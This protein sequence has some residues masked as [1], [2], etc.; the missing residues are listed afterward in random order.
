MAKCKFLY[1]FF[2]ALFYIS[3]HEKPG[4]I[5]KTAPP[6][7]N[8]I[9]S[10]KKKAKEIKKVVPNSK[11]AT[12]FFTQYGKDNPETGAII[13]TDLGDIHLK[14]F[15]DTPLHRAS[16]V[17]LVKEGYFDLT[18]FH[19]V[20]PDFIIQGGNGDT[21]AVANFKN[22][23]RNYKIPPEFRKNH[24]HKR[25]ALA[26]AREWEYNP[27]KVTT[28]FEFYIIL[29]VDD[30]GHLDGEHTVFGQV[31]KG[32]DVVDAISVVRVSRDEWPMENINMTI[33]LLE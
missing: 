24:P 17:Y 2:V 5:Q 31:T 10:P 6:K 23:L 30:Y 22:K 32:M 8:T 18:C 3:C 19:R 9:V 4:V 7:K 16:F 29:G 14:L 33:K 20:V 1:L 25:G 11:N 15:R 21:E 27:D 28:P 13:Q 26:A 12:T